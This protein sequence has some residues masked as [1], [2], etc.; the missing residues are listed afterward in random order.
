MLFSSP[1][2]SVSAD[3]LP[4]NGAV[5]V[6]VFTVEEEIYDDGVYR[7]R[8]AGF[9]VSDSTNE[10]ILKIAP[11]FDRPALITLP[12]GKYLFESKTPHPIKKTI[13]IE[14]STLYKVNLH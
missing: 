13:I 3:T 4:D 14:G 9:C 1:Q 12:K 8:Y 11:K 6:E 7:K 2:Y 10:I 5:M